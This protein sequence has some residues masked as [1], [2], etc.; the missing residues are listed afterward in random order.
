[1]MWEGSFKKAFEQIN[2]NKITIHARPEG[3]V[4]F[5]EASST[6]TMLLTGNKCGIY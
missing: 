5:N 2:D 6:L 4:W 3:P 1:M